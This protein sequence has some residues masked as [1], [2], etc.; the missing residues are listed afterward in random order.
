MPVEIGFPLTLVTF[1]MTGRIDIHRCYLKDL[2]EC[3][4]HSGEN[5]LE[6]EEAKEEEAKEEVKEE[7]KE[8]E[9]GKEEEFEIKAPSLTGFSGMF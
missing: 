5:E 6:I 3:L 1:A 8:E 9:G 7:S 4:Y 2:K